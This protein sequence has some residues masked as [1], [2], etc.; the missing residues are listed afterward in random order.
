VSDASVLLRDIAGDGAAKAAGK[1]N[2]SE[3]RLNQID[4]PAADNTWHEVPDLSKENLKNQATSTFKKNTPVDKQDLQDAKNNAQSE[5]DNQGAASTGISTL[6]DRASQ[7]IPD[8]HKDRAAEAKDNTKAKTKN[9][10]SNKIPQERREQTIWRLKKMVVEIQGHEDYQQ[11]ITTLLDL[12]E[13]YAGHG[14]DISLQ[15]K[16]NVKGVRQDSALQTAENDLKTLIERFANGTSTDDFFESLNQIYRD[17]QED[18]KLKNWFKKMDAYV[19]KCLKEQGYIMQDSATQEYNE[20]YDEGQ[21]LLRDRYRAHTD[22]IVDQ[23]KFIADQFAQ[24]PQ[25]Q[26]FGNSLQ[27]LFNDLGTDENGKATFKPHLLKD[28]TNVILPAAFEHVRYVPIPRIEYSDPMM[29]CIVE[30]LVLESDNLA[31]NTLEI[32]NDNYIRWGRKKISNKNRHSVMVSA[33]GIQCDLRDVS[34][35]VNKKQGFPSVKDQGVADIFLGGEGFSFKLKLSTAEKK[36][37]QAFFKVDKVD[38]VIKHLN[39]KL[40]KSNH[41]LLFGLVK[42]ILLK[43]MSPVVQKVLEKQI[44]DS[45]NQFDSLAYRVHQEVEKTKADLINNPDPENA[46][47]IYQNYFETFRSQMLA[48]KQKSQEVAADKKVNVAMTQHD[49][50]FKDIKLEKGISTKATEYKELA[51]KGDK[52]ESPIFGFGSAAEST[53]IPSAPTISRKSH[54]HTQPGLTGGET[55]NAASSHPDSYT[56]SGTNGNTNGFRN[57]V[58]QAFDS[59]NS[60]GG[61]S[62]G[63]SGNGY[64]IGQPLAGKTNGS[65][66]T[67]GNATNGT[68]AH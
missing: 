19:R 51:A 36:D 20:L 27:K 2:P 25:N 44:K 13:Q 43:V 16:E 39:I 66:V 57:E 30:N 38:V 63:T 68:V 31:P 61:L 46:K 3:E 10:I 29:D 33:S 55:G 8:E 47:N 56:T 67:N 24:D 37:Q 22:N 35:Y 1:L 45:F 48:G 18:P 15:S 32:A 62:N 54:S 53:N 17:A 7:N 14:K 58:S 12:A 65:A 23:T 60:N 4:E 64:T 41:K 6:K 40:K 50:I 28:V 49:S 5:G 42:P 11:A 26:Q 21:F 59:G 52:W 9:Y 34:Y